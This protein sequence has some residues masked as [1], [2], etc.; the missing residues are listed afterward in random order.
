L[1]TNPPSSCPSEIYREL[2]RAAQTGDLHNTKIKDNKA[3][4]LKG[5]L[6]KKTAGVIDGQGFSDINS[7]VSAATA[8]D[9]TP[10]LYIIPLDRVANLVTPVPVG[11]LAHPLSI[12]FIIEYLPSDSF[13]IIQFPGVP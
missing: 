5:A 13:D 6:A 12:E 7:I 1:Y 4:I 8:Q 11:Q 2:W 3:G 10:I 9:F